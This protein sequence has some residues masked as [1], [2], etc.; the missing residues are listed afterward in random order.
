[1][2]LGIGQLSN[3]SISHNF[4]WPCGCVYIMWLCVVVTCSCQSSQIQIS[5]LEIWF[6]FNMKYIYNGIVTC[7]RIHRDRICWSLWTRECEIL[8][9]YFVIFGVFL[10]WLEIWT[11]WG[12]GRRCWLGIDMTGQNLECF[13]YGRGLAFKLVPNPFSVHAFTLCWSV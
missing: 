7:I 1:M 6:N 11:C 13:I 10:I 3:D 2:L 8:A 4:I 5:N 9:D 12:V